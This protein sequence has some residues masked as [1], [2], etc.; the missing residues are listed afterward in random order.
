[1]LQLN[2]SWAIKLFALLASSFEQAILLDADAVMVQ[3]PGNV[4]NYS[5][6]LETG[7]YL[8]H[9][10]L[11]WQPGFQDRHDW[12][13]DQMAH[14]TQSPALLKSL[15]WTEDYAEEQDSGMIVM[16]KCRLGIV[17]ALLHICWQ[18]SHSIR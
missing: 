14:N 9:D 10:R 5:D 6:Y 15:V 18:N 13:G 4:F 16:D 12:W 8:F 3:D 1:L 11:L 2:G 7:T 17:T